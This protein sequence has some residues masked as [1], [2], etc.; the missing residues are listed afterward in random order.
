MAYLREITAVRNIGVR[1]FDRGSMGVTP[2][3]TSQD[4]ADMGWVARDARLIILGD[5]CERNS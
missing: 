5:A 1:P 2:A 4:C 3:I